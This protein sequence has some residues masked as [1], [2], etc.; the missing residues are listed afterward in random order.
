MKDLI[1]HVSII[2]FLCLSCNNN[3]KHIEVPTN[4]I[5]N[6]EDSCII[7]KNQSTINN[8][9]FELN[10]QD[11]TIVILNQFLNDYTNH[12][13]HYNRCINTIIKGW[14]EEDLRFKL[15]E[16]VE[17]LNYS[18]DSFNGFFFLVQF[19]RVSHDAEL[20]ESVSQTIYQ[21]ALETPER[22]ISFYDSFESKSERFGFLSEI[23]LSEQHVYEINK[24]LQ[25]SKYSEDIKEYSGL[26][27]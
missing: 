14:Y 25:K 24:I 9:V 2:S 3:K 27:H 19:Q 8:Q 7:L 4:I 10:N 5:N 15:L 6:Y 21:M 13:Y 23:L 1:Y 22:F 26:D 18:V 16:K 17:E 12:K 20:A 11:S